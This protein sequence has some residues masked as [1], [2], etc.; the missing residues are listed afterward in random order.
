MHFVFVS[1]STGSHGISLSQWFR[2][3]LF[4]TVKI[5]HDWAVH[6]FFSPVTQSNLVLLLFLPLALLFGDLVEGIDDGR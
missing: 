1:F 4:E 3:Q 6:V 2:V 5:G